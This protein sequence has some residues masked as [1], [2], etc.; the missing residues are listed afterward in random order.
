MKILTYIKIGVG[1][2]IVAL[3]IAGFFWLR[4]ATKNNYID[5]GTSEA[6][7]LTPTQIQS[8][9]AIGEWEFLSV[10]TEELV[11]TVRKG[12]FSDDELVRIYYGTL[13]LG[14]NMQK[15]GDDWIQTSGDS[16]TLTLPKIELLDKEFIDEARTKSFY[17]R[18]SWKPADRDALYQKA[19]RQM[20]SHSMTKENLQA[21]EANAS[22]Q[23]HD[24]MRALGYQHVSI[25]FQKK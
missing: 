24:I 5:F 23:M 4:G 12:I 2:V 6:I 13:R 10:S 22:Q 20:L 16:I 18:G 14:V 7:D 11:D 25:T 1:L 15:V 19:Y 8:M 21:A 3:L 17:E 9:K